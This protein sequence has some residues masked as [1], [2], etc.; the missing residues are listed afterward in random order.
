MVKQDAQ[1]H[2]LEPVHLLPNSLG[3]SVRR[4]QLEDLERVDNKSALFARTSVSDPDSIRSVDP[5]SKKT[6]MT[7]KS[8][9]KLRNFM[10]W[11]AG[12]SLLR[13][14]GFFCNGSLEIL[15]GGLGIGK[16]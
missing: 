5:G 16:L 14:E 11:S 13:A 3:L 7:H 12:C 9:K 2:C 10:F 4:L 6:K 8:R 15:Y 1:E